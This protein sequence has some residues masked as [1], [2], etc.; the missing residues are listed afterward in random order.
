MAGVSCRKDENRIDYNPTLSYADHSRAEQSSSSS[1]P[2][3][4]LARSPPLCIYQICVH[5]VRVI[6]LVSRATTATYSSN[7]K[8][9]I[10]YTLTAS[11]FTPPFH[12]SLNKLIINVIRLDFVDTIA[13]FAPSTPLPL[14]AM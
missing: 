5:V 13:F 1:S 9:S 6:V 8:Y 14:L 3:R 11:A 10:V 2:R 4:L 7:I 12:L